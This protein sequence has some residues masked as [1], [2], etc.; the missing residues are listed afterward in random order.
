MHHGTQRRGAQKIWCTAYWYTAVMVHS[1]SGTQRRGA[2]KIWCT[3]HM[4]HSVFATHVCGDCA[5]LL[6]SVHQM[7]CTIDA[8]HPIFGTPYTSTCCTEHMV[9]SMHDTQRVCLTAYAVIVLCFQLK[10]LKPYVHIHGL[11][12]NCTEN[13]DQTASSR[14]FLPKTLCAH[15]HYMVLAFLINMT[16]THTTPDNFA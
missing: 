14:T 1:V 11:G 6:F 9:H 16:Y 13:P 7:L 12:H 8:V 5:V 2:Q 3:V 4:A 10:I 15:R